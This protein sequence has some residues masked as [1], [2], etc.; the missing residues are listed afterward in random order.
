MLPSTTTA[1]F[2]INMSLIK[3][4][5][6]VDEFLKKY[7]HVRIVKVILLDDGGLDLATFLDPRQLQ[8]VDDLHIVMRLFWAP[9]LHL[10]GDLSAAFPNHAPLKI[11]QL[12]LIKLKKAK[13][14]RDGPTLRCL[15]LE[16]LSDWRPSGRM[17][18]LREGQCLDYY[19]IMAANA[20][21]ERL[22]RRYPSGSGHVPFTTDK[23]IVSV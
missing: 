16:A 18:I 21:V 6:T 12:V 11:V 2:P 15:K 7:C 22:E 13:A 9:E 4:P 1:A 23:R 10:F 20:G 8:S 19:K 17:R 5:L 3:A 14:G